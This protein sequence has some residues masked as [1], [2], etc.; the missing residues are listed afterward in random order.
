MSKMLKAK[1]T[2]LFA[3]AALAGG[4]VISPGTS[5]AD[6]AEQSVVGG[7]GSHPHHVH[8][9]NGGCVDINRVFFEVDDRGLHRGADS[10]NEHESGPYHG[11]CH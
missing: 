1:L 2:A 11:P 5:F 4:L 7:P 9:G 10:S 3:I 8:T 6:P